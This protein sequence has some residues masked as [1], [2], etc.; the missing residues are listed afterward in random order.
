MFFEKRIWHTKNGDFVKVIIT[1][2]PTLKTPLLPEKSLQE[3]LDEAVKNEEFEKAAILRDL[4]KKEK[5][6]K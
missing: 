3:K 4:I 1:D 2:E 6:S 5:K